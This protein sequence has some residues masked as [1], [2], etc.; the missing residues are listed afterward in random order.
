MLLPRVSRCPAQQA[1][2]HVLR[3]VRVGAVQAPHIQLCHRLTILLAITGAR[4]SVHCAGSAEALQQHAGGGPYFSSGCQPV[5][6]AAHAA[7]MQL[8]QWLWPWAAEQL[9]LTSAELGVTCK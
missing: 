4:C 7:D 8:A 9:H 1:S 3:S 5:A 6:P 2:Q